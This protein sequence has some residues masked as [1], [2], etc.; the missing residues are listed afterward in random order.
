MLGAAGIETIAIHADHIN[1][2]K[3]GLK[4]DSTYRTVASH[5]WVMAISAGDTVSR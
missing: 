2:V 4:S 3:F 1:M 5:L